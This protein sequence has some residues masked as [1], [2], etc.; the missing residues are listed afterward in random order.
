MLGSTTDQHVTA[1][2]GPK[3]KQ[4]M[5]PLVLAGEVAMAGYVA[6][7]WGSRR[8]RRTAETECGF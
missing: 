2:S 7:M 5:A 4:V 3:Q 1:Q 6:A 8:S